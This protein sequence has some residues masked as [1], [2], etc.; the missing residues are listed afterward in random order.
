MAVAFS[1]INQEITVTIQ[2]EV[3]VRKDIFSA[4]VHWVKESDNAKYLQALR[5]VGGDGIG[6]SNESPNFFFLMN[7][8]KI[9][10]DGIVATFKFNLYCE[11]AT[12][13][14][15]VPFVYINGG[16][17]NNEI[18]SSPVISGGSVLTTEEHDRLFE[19]A[20][21]ADVYAAKYS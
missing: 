9:V 3:D 1:G 5:P 4:W 17:S 18:S 13:D 8:W 19:T 21:A 6:N 15:Y 2:T 20:T 11:E 10:V 14:N 16:H 7:N 12:N